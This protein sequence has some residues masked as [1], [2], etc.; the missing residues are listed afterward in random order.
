MYIKC[1]L[2]IGKTFRYIFWLSWRCSISELLSVFDVQPI[3]NIIE[4]NVN[5]FL[6]SSLNSNKPNADLRFLTRLIMLD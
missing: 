2:P 3:E 4:N 1:I 6:I 5:K